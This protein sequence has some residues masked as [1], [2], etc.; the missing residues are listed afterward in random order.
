MVPSSVLDNWASEL[1]KFCPALDC[2]KYHGS[3]KDRSAMRQSL[4]GVAAGGE[5][6]S[7]PVRLFIV[8]VRVRQPIKWN[9]ES[10]LYCV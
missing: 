3:Q 4:N 5:R 2:V 7:M 10:I 8:P 9:I 6:E 1:V